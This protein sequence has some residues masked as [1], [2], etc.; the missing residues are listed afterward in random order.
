MQ[1]L[2]IQGIEE[3]YVR[4]LE[5][6]YRES[7][8]TTEQGYAISPK[9]F[10]ACLEEIFKNLDWEQLGVKIDG[11]YLSNL[12]FTDDVV[13]LSDSGDDLQRMIGE[14]H[15]E[16][17]KVGLRINTK[18]TKIMYNDHACNQQTL[19]VIK[20]NDEVIEEVKE[21]TYL[22]QTVNASPVHEKEIR[23]RIGM[24]WR[25]FV[26]QNNIMRGNMALSLK[27][28]VYNQNVLPVLT[29]G[30]ETWG[31]TRASERKLRNTQKEMERI[32]LGFWRERRQD[33]WTN[34]Q[35]GVE[36]ILKTIK[37]RKWTW[38]GH[39]IRRTDNRW[40]V[41]VTDWQPRDGRSITQAR[42][43]TFRWRDEIRDFAGNGWG[44]LTADRE[45]WR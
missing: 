45:Q 42:Q 7:T 11:E 40:T 41:R 25:A 30:S 9:L 21:H 15:A 1:A 43:R 22:G 2:R 44:K 18:T 36:D 14:L 13:L 27:R 32:M 8:L 33:V 24:G 26:K 37:K 4:V 23:R 6:T 16:S 39:V 17:L 10:T 12:R 34:D 35:T 31:L 29:Y 28:K 5:D 38:A 20:L 3:I 19:P